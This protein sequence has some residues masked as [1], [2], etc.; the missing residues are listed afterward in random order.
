MAGA[1]RG[2][3]VLMLKTGIRKRMVFVRLVDFRGRR[4]ERSVE[5]KCRKLGNFV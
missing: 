4:V 5:K 1:N 3:K 2:A